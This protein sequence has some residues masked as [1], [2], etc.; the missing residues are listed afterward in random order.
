MLLISGR[1][2]RSPTKGATPGGAPAGRQTPPVAPPEPY[3][4]PSSEPPNERLPGNVPPVY[5]PGQIPLYPE[6]RPLTPL[7]RR[8]ARQ[9][10]VAARPSVRSPGTETDPSNRARPQTN[11]D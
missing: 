4:E 3:V 10:H 9:I 2:D 7:T 6:P 5:P 11:R 1:A 8:D